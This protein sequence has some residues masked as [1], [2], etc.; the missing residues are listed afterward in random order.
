MATLLLLAVA[1]LVGV[2]IIVSVYFW[3]LR[4]RRRGGQFPEWLKYIGRT[5][6]VLNSLMLVDAFLFLLIGVIYLLATS[7]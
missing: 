5:L 7:K 1:L 4:L 2:P 6:R 3:A